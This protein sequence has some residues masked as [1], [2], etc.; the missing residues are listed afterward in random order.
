MSVQRKLAA[1]L[2]ADVVGYSRLIGAD[3]E[4]SLAT[5]NTY[6]QVT[7]GLVPSHRGRVFG[8]SESY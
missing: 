1:I 7:D 8:S 4:A 6:R 5:L 2:S 3:E